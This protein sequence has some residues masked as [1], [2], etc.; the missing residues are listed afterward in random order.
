MYILMLAWAFFSLLVSDVSSNLFQG[1]RK[2]SRV[3]WLSSVGSQ[4]TNDKGALRRRDPPRVE[5]EGW[6][7][8]S[9]LK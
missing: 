3:V 6:Q 7:R 9:H 8:R 2:D 1:R 4:E 5:R